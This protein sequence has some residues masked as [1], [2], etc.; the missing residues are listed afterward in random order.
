M[1]DILLYT[2]EGY[3]AKVFIPEVIMKI[4]LAI[5]SNLACLFNHISIAVHTRA[6]GI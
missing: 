1:L 4:L 3:F 2:T 5:Q 6:M